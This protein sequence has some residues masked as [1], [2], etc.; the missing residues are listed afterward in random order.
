M[1]VVY[2]FPMKSSR[3]FSSASTLYSY[4]YGAGW[5]LDGK[6]QMFTA[7]PGYVYFVDTMSFALGVDQA[8]FISGISIVPTVTIEN[9]LGQSLN[10]IGKKLVSYCSD[11]PYGFFYSSD[12]QVNIF[13]HLTGRVMQTS[14]LLGSDTLVSALSF[15][16]YEISSTALSGAYRDSI[17]SNA[18]NVFRGTL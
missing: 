6:F 10:G 5:E 15:S 4:V 9:D 17:S 7:K 13:C 1:S 3:L 2:T 11:T 18:K 8:D 12:T 14:A 16:V